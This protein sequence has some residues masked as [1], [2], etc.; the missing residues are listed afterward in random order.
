MTAHASLLDA[1]FATTSDAVF[2]TD[3]E[4]RIERINKAFERLTG[5]SEDELQGTEGNALF[6]NNRADDAPEDLFSNPDGMDLSDVQARTKTGSV[7]IHGLSVSPI[8]R[9]AVV[10]NFMV[11]VTKPVVLERADG[12]LVGHDELTDLPNRSLLSDRADQAILNAS[13]DGKSI[14]MLVMGLDRFGVVNDALG[15]GAGDRLLKGIAERLN[16]VI[17]VSDTAARLDGDKFAV[18]TPISANDDSVIVAEKVL[19]ATKEPFDIDG[20][21][22]VLSFSIGI[23]IFP[24]DAQTA[25]TLIADALSAMQHGKTRGGDQYQF[26][27]TEMNAKA[28]SRLDL[29]KRLR[30]ALQEEEFLLYYQP[31]VDVESDRVKG[32]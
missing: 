18:M 24:Q 12:T 7:H 26:F 19:K 8:G 1:V 11:I 15:Y 4:G 9:A 17:R 6:F 3:G 31:K 13:R 5:F 23:S 14:A 27:A 10:E 28:K 16:M 21:E 32:A 22:V 29:E 25:D 20:E 30:R 2:V